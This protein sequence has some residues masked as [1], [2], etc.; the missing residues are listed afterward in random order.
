[1][2]PRADAAD[3]C[4]A[5]RDASCGSGS[6]DEGPDLD[7]RAGVETRVK[8]VCYSPAGHR[9]QKLSENSGVRQDGQLV[10]QVE[11]QLVKEWNGTENTYCPDVFQL[12]GLLSEQASYAWA[13]RLDCHGFPGHQN[14]MSGMD[15]QSGTLISL[16]SASG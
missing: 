14:P 8:A 7:I 6:P 9:R 5:K 1:M 10:S 2:T 16:T 13:I 4:H 15:G 3:K 12:P 11:C